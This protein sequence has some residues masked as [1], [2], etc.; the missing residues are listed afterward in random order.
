MSTQTPT[1]TSAEP[2][3]FGEP[4]GPAHQWQIPLL[5]VSMGL[6][7]VSLLQLRPQAPPPT[8]EE[9]LEPLQRMMRAGL[10]DLVVADAG[11]LLREVELAP[12][13]QARL[14]V[15]MAQATYLA[16]R[17]NTSLTSSAPTRRNSSLTTA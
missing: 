15:L 12:L 6:L 8:F 5:L 10:Y 13:E 7:V 16:E 17:W 2:Q 4:I 3:Q 1:E 11:T 14:Y 9:H